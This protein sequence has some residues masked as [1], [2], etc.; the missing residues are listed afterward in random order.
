MATE[1][2]LE[3]VYASVFCGLQLDRTKRRV[4]LQTCP[5]LL[6]DAYCNNGIYCLYYLLNLLK[7]G[8]TDVPCQTD[9]IKCCERALN[10]ESYR[11][12]LKEMLLHYSKSVTNLCAVCFKIAEEGRV[13]VKF[14]ELC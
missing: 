13:V 1:F 4:F 6:Q 8:R 10:A 5:H 3:P 12:E 9:L 11:S 2:V 14:V 7:E